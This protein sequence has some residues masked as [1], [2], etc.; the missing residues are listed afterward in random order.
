[1]SHVTLQD[2]RDISDHVNALNTHRTNRA[3]AAADFVVALVVA[4]LGTLAII[5]FALPCE[6]ASLCLLAAVPT[7]R[8]WLQRLLDKFESW[9]LM[10]AI[11]SAQLDLQWQY[12]NLEI[13]RWE[14]DHI[15]QQ[16]KL[17]RAHIDQLEA[18][19]YALGGGAAGA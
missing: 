7:Q 10:R 2:S 4:M 8:N 15:P 13:A 3:T 11:R 14:C 17:T 1:M 12:E 16:Q 9:R 19:L 18:R 5:H 6:G